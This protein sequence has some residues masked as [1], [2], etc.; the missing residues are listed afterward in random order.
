LRNLRSDAQTGEEMEIKNKLIIVEGLTGL[1]KST[2]AHF[3]K[4]QLDY[5]TIPHIWIH[6][7]ELSHPILLED[8]EEKEFDQKEYTSLMQERWVDFLESCASQEKVAVV[9]GIYFNN[10][11]EE[12][13]LNNAGE[14]AIHAFARQ[15]EAVILP[16]N[17][18]LIY[19]KRPD[20]PKALA[21]NFKNRG[22]DFKGFVID[23]VN[24]TPWAKTRKL[25]GYDGM[26]MFW[27]ELW[28]IL[29]QVFQG[30]SLDK[31][32]I[33]SSD[34]KWEEINLKVLDFLGLSYVPEH[35]LTKIESEKFI[36]EYQIENS[37]QTW[38]IWYDDEH[39]RL[40][41]N[42]RTVLVPLGEMRFGMR[43]FKFELLFT[44]EEAGAVDGFEVQGEDIDYMRFVGISGQKRV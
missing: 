9:E 29:D 1:G 41:I 5:H 30:Y 23:Y 7:C 19:L 8:I 10:M 11:I 27:Q 28:A 17:P 44:Q 24:S 15:M 36:G 21:W 33:D 37:D 13:F 39:Q 6:E 22:D 12:L 43:S 16:Y 34:G 20:I 32:E 38:Q 14:E 18:A 40:M 4:R 31:L 26:V 35:P 3:I 25:S 2:M 42:Q